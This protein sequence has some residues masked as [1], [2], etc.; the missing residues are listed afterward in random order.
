MNKTNLVGLLFAY[1][2]KNFI[3]SLGPTPLVFPMLL[4]FASFFLKIYKY[5]YIYWV[6]LYINILTKRWQ[7][8]KKFEIWK[9]KLLLNI[10]V[11]K[12]LFQQC[13]YCSTGLYHIHILWINNTFFY[14][15]QIVI[16]IQRHYILCCRRKEYK[17]EVLAQDFFFCCS[18]IENQK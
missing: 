9:K 4:L 5:V 14:C 16:Y 18:A 12:Q 2:K 3:M 15:V 6:S 17:L 1:E 13:C 8:F 10:R 11:W 7:Q